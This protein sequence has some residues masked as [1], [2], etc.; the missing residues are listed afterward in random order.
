MALRRASQKLKESEI[1]F[2]SGVNEDLAA[3]SVWGSQQAILMPQPRFQG[4]F[5]L[6]YG[7]GP[8]VDR[9]RGRPEAR[10][11]RRGLRAR[12]CR[13][14]CRRRP[15]S[16][17]LAASPER[18]RLRP[19]SIPVLYPSTPQEFLEYGML[20]WHTSR[21][22]GSDRDAMLTDIVE[23]AGSIDLRQLRRSFVDPDITADPERFI[24]EPPAARPGANGFDVRLPL[25][26]EVARRQPARPIGVRQRLRQVR[27][28]HGRQGAP[29]RREALVTLGIDE[30]RRGRS[31][32]ACS[33]SA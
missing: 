11:L 8:G 20:A 18:A 1:V 13:R 29:R 27:H 14:S 10:E 16:N 12:R 26:Q 7:K 5:G 25:V 22:S 32:S 17:R 4:V 19:L 23:S 15:W 28:R 21:F 24:V 33:R 31:A 30:E 9:S 2:E 6:W 3:T